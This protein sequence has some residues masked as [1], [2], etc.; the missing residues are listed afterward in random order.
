[1]SKPNV[2]QL[3]ACVLAT[4]LSFVRGSAAEEPVTSAI[5][6]V[7]RIGLDNGLSV[8]FAPDPQLHDVS[9]VVAYAAGRADDPTGMEGLAHVTEHVIFGASREAPVSTLVAA[10]ATNLNAHTRFDDTTFEETVPREAL[11]RALW[12]EAARMTA[13]PSCATDAGTA[14]ERAVVAEEYRENGHGTGALPTPLFEGVWDEFFPAWHPYHLTVDELT[15]LGRIG[16][17]DVRAFAATW[18]RPNNATLVVIGNFDEPSA[19][20]LVRT[21]FGAIPRNQVPARP[22]LPPVPPPGDLWIDVEALVTHA[23]AIVAWRAPTVDEATPAALELGLTVL[24]GPH[25]PLREFVRPGGPALEA[26]LSLLP[27][28]AGSLVLLR[29]V[30]HAGVPLADVL[31]AIQRAVSRASEELTEADVD[32]ARTARSEHLLMDLETSMGRAMLF[33]TADVHG[34]AVDEYADLGAAA[35]TRTMRQVFVR[36][37]RVTMVVRPPTRSLFGSPAVLL[38]RE[39]LLP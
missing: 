3:A 37:G 10:G 12:L 4:A 16:A 36:E 7:E 35:V 32:L 2:V 22:E 18:Y 20:R 21:Y 19:A 28:S 26:D 5:P 29:I 24:N 13:A 11:D 34:R 25:G 27:G 23:Q 31:P 30:P 9:V 33:A 8:V 15:T 14:R 39:R 6:A 17:A 38:H 1:M